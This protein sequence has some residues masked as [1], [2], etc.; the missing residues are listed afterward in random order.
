MHCR[1]WDYL[2][3]QH[4]RDQPRYRKSGER[5]LVH[6]LQVRK[7][8]INLTICIEMTGKKGSPEKDL[9]Q[10]WCINTASPHHKVCSQTIRFHIAI[11]YSFVTR[12][13]DHFKVYK[14]RC[15]KLG[16]TMHEHAIPNTC[17]IDWRSVCFTSNAT[18][19]YF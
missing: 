13:N 19:C 14:E 18:C 12:H 15:S 7:L 2:Y 17:E 8:Y 1:H 11:A 10:R 9:L 16:I 5:S 3:V 6:H 4:C